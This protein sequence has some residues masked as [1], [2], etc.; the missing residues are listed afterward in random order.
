[1]LVRSLVHAVMIGAHKLAILQPESKIR[2][3]KQR[4]KRENVI[5]INL[6]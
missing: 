1:M 5:K 6:E 2:F 4:H 3:G